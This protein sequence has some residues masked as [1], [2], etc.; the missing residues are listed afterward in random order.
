MSSIKDKLFCG[1][2]YL[3]PQHLLSRLG[4]RL[5]ESK[6]P[7][8]KNFLVGVFIRKFQVN[9][10]EACDQNLNAYTSFNDFFTRAL[11]PSARPIVEDANALTSPADGTISQCGDI[12]QGQLIQAKGLSY[13][14]SDLIGDET[15]ASQFLDGKF[16][17]TYLSP[18]DYH[19]VHMPL[20]GKLM[21]SNYIPG[22][23]FSVNGVTASMIP[24][25]FARNERL[26]CLFESQ[27]GPF[28]L[29]MVGA[30][31]VAGIE[32]VWQG[33]Y[34][35]NKSLVCNHRDDHGNSSLRFD[36]GAE[37]GRFKFGSTVILL[38]PNQLRLEARLEPGLTVKVGEIV[39][40]SLVDEVSDAS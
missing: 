17:T 14:A 25:L 16:I 4:A 13:L 34:S 3:L 18:R 10:S 38:L 36:K 12:T 7:W 37:I 15:I 9:M 6:L 8:L 11:M 28:V 35:P 40:M 39:A 29:I 27:H 33:S 26:V 32:S 1:L 22:R 24:G 30:I 5:A 23:L 20:S 21:Q 19:R 31:M 2:Q